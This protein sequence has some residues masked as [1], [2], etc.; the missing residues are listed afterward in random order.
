M[1]NNKM[2]REEK[3]RLLLN[4]KY[5][6][7]DALTNEENFARRDRSAHFLNASTN[8]TLVRTSIS[9][10]MLA[11]V[12]AIVFV[13]TVVPTTVFLSLRG[14]ADPFYTLNPVQM[15][16]RINGVMSESADTAIEAGIIQE[17]INAVNVNLPE[18]A[19]FVKAILLEE[20]GKTE[21][22][23]A[24]VGNI[25][26]QDFYSLF[27]SVGE[28]TAQAGDIG[29]ATTEN[30]K[31]VLVYAN[32]YNL[33]I[34]KNGEGSF[35]TSAGNKSYIYAGEDF[36]VSQIEPD[37]DYKATTVQYSTEYTNGTVNIKNG[38]ATIPAAEIVGNLHIVV[39]YVKNTGY[40]IIDV[41]NANN[42]GNGG[43]AET[44]GNQVLQKSE[45]RQRYNPNPVPV[46]DDGSNTKTFLMYSNS[47][48]GGSTYVLN[49]FRIN[50][51][52]VEVSSVNTIAVSETLP[53]QT[54]VVIEL[55]EDINGQGMYWLDN[56]P[57]A[58]LES[59]HDRDGKFTHSGT[60]YTFNNEWN[61]TRTIYRV[62]V[63]N[64]HKNLNV[65]YNFKKKNNA[66]LII[67]NRT[68]IAETA[69][70]KETVD[71]VSYEYFFNPQST[72]IYP[73]YYNQMGIGGLGC[74]SA[75]LYLYK[76]KPGY[77]PYVYDEAKVFYVDDD[78][79]SVLDA[80][81]ILSTNI[82]TP[83]EAI[84]TA[85]AGEVSEL[86]N[87]DYTKFDIRYRQWGGRGK[88]PE[89]WNDDNERDGWFGEY[90][91]LSKI[92][93][94]DD[95]D[96]WYAIALKQNPS[97]NQQLYLALKP[98]DYRIELDLDHGILDASD[99]ENYA[100]D[101]A[102]GLL[103]ETKATHIS[104]AAP[105]SY[106]PTKEPTRDGYYFK[107]WQQVDK[108]NRTIGELQKAATRV[109]IDE[110]T[111]QTAIGEVR[112]EE[113]TFRY[114]AVWEAK[115]VADKTTAT[116]NI[117]VEDPS[118]TVSANEKLY[119][120]VYTNTSVQNVGDAVVLNNHSDVLGDQANYYYVN[121]A[122]DTIA[123]LVN[124]TEYNPNP[125][126]LNIYYDYKMYDLTVNNS[127]L[128]YPETQTYPVTIILT[129][130]EDSP[131]ADISEEDAKSLFI[132]SESSVAGRLEKN[133]EGTFTYTVNMQGGDSAV[134]HLP[135][136][137]AYLISEEE[138]EEDYKTVITPSTTGTMDKNKTVEITNMQ[139]N[140]G[141]KTEKTLKLQSDGTYNIVLK[142]W[143]T[144]ASYLKPLTNATP[145]DIVLVIDQSG[146]M[147]TEDMASS[148]EY[149]VVK[150]NGVEKRGWTID[151]ATNGGEV[152]YYYDS[153]TDEYYP[154]TAVKGPLYEPA[155][156][157]APNRMF[158]AGNDG[159]AT[160]SIGNYGGSPV[161]FNVPS[162]Y[163][164]LYNNEMKH[165][166]NITVGASLHW[167]I[168]PYIYTDSN[169]EMTS[170][171]YNNGSK[172]NETIQWFDADFIGALLDGKKPW[173]LWQARFMYEKHGGL[174]GQKYNPSAYWN[175]LS[176]NVRF[177]NPDGTLTT[178]GSYTSADQHYQDYV[179]TLGTDATQIS[180]LYTKVAG[181][182]YN[183]I[184]FNNGT[185]THRIGNKI[186]F[187]G[188]DVYD[189]V[190]YRVK[191]QSRVSALQENVAK[192]V[193][194]LAKSA[195][196]TGADHRMAIVGFAGNKVPYKS[197]GK[198]AY[199][200]TKY[201]Y[202]NTGLFLNGSFK[203]YEQFTVNP[204][205]YTGTKYINHHYFILVNGEYVPVKYNSG[206]NQWQT[207][208]GDEATGSFYEA[209]YEALDE[210]DY[211]DA[212]EHIVDENDTHYYDIQ[213]QR[214][215]ETNHNGITD[216][217]DQSISEF[218][219]YGGTFTSYGMTMA[220]NIL[221]YNDEDDGREKIIIVFTDGEPGLN[222][223]D[224]AIAGEA[225]V[226]ANLAKTEYGA[227][228]YTIGL[229]RDDPSSNVEEFMAD[230]SSEYFASLN[231]VSAGAQNKGSLDAS[232]SYYYKEVDGSGNET[233]KTYSVSAQ[234]DGKSTLGW[235]VSH[236]LNDNSY[237]YWQVTP[238]SE[239]GAGTQ[240]FYNSRGNKVNKDWDESNN[241]PYYDED[242]N[243]IRYEY[244]WYDSNNRIREPVGGDTTNPNKTQFYE[245]GEKTPKTDTATYNY[246]A[247]NASSLNRIFDKVTS[248]IASMMVEVTLDE[249]NSLMKDVIT[250][251]F[252]VSDAHATAKEVK[253]RSVNG[254]IIE[255]EMETSLS[256]PD[257]DKD[258]STV[259][260]DGW[261]YSANYIG[262]DRTE[263]N[264]GSKLVVTITGLKP[265]RT[266]FNLP[267]N[268][269]ESGVYEKLFENPEDEDEQTGIQML[270]AYEIPE[271]NRPGYTLVTDG[272]DT[273][274]TYTVKLKLIDKD[275]NVLTQG[276]WERLNNET[277]LA[278]L[279]TPDEDGFAV[280]TTSKSNNDPEDVQTDTVVLEDVFRNLPEGYKVYVKVSKS[281]DNTN[282]F[283][284]SLKLNDKVTTDDETTIPNW[285]EP[286]EVADGDEIEI[287]SVRKTTPVTIKEVT[288]AKDGDADFSDPEKDFDIVLKLKDIDGE[289][290]SDTFNGVTF[291]NGVAT[292]KMHDGMSRTINIPKGYSLEIDVD[293]E[294]QSPY[295]D[296]Y[297]QGETQLEGEKF[298][299]T[300]IN[301]ATTI[302]V[303]NEIAAPPATGYS[304]GNTNFS[305]FFYV[306]VGLVALGAGAWFAVRYRRKKEQ[307]LSAYLAS[308][309][310]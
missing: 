220:N 273:D 31:L 48:T 71:G 132:S 159:N 262:D 197:S 308:K 186:N 291:E 309:S 234:R 263:D 40:S 162:N 121:L 27:E 13:L 77:N 244:R 39:N 248:S 25:D 33:S 236:R 298:G 171:M 54:H 115:E 173:E 226:D 211:Q 113:H 269:D 7:E 75:N 70:A 30:Q 304:D 133:E 117:L 169:T 187:E 109:T 295:Y 97:K 89:I 181:T 231:Q 128:G 85:T 239:S 222:G 238:I 155:D 284:Y 198:T 164:A 42:N 1:K 15:Y 24:A 174:S 123:E 130:D 102:T 67:K 207:L 143:A 21:T 274:A 36:R 245:I 35:N 44:Q 58:T 148:L 235:W 19:E 79:N 150:E 178:D 192:F 218:G 201:D 184:G 194:E 124:Q 288:K 253:C 129:A 258:T 266:G 37:V 243:L 275:G 289:D 47:N 247:E 227:K 84:S 53:D 78:G 61:K 167:K 282:L 156:P 114:V 272:D 204:Q 43:I 240:Q 215:S 107:G 293:P 251:C 161:F 8:S 151:E 125:N 14:K 110:N 88:T 29:T 296:S 191:G 119:R 185:D 213:R 98:Y 146:S 20:D 59:Q 254:E 51:Q 3:R 17:N 182:T 277:P 208:D 237:E 10:S 57:D 176:Q 256:N 202:T 135:Y 90:F 140:S 294:T 46:T 12:L 301:D 65:E 94:R 111:I 232:K 56:K 86:T 219:N 195:Q 68:G 270:Q 281:G 228:V 190:L 193:D 105:Y 170:G 145:L 223:F 214:Y 9:K 112:D 52:E 233:G 216:Q 165:V 126:I 73:A 297:K 305:I 32:K 153:D 152:Y 206:N 267:S 241:T 189:Q 205:P 229:F 221:R 179:Y 76:V 278:Q 108:T 177:V 280:W 287:D 101:S 255:T 82:G 60:T 249:H 80:N 259:S 283:D 292:L 118:G 172:W 131:L 138:N 28:G 175:G 158:G 41:S 26:N 199:D 136:N 16:T 302:T 74:P 93:Q 203:N 5:V 252:D 81:A 104:D 120:N 225:T 100:S 127:V 264:L 92:G 122:S 134:L 310:E 91:V 63:S 183:G 303:F 69:N 217:I 300:S 279:G 11:I 257:F 166:Y 299:P 23:I 188:E 103:K 230:L 2:T 139:N 99:A 141:V 285:N 149:E 116:V 18:G 260:V 147:G 95:S 163:Y 168:Y 210:A 144:N 196:K 271:V 22:E 106:L 265:T 72:H 157:I 242:G 62:T 38:E 224:S 96:D 4:K 137:W 209:S 142:S 64:V 50:G 45:F 212:L 160:L 261:N 87:V 286:F 34:Q 246:R 55:A 307:E 6:K 306:A 49:M 276:Q 154:V 180:N 290:V 83:E 66:E 268:T 250:D 200:T